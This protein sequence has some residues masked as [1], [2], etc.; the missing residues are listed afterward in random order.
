[1]FIRCLDPI[2][3]ILQD[4]MSILM[5]ASK[6]PEKALRHI[7]ELVVGEAFHTEQQHHNGSILMRLL[8]KAYNESQ[9]GLRTFLAKRYK[10]TLVDCVRF[11][12]LTLPDVQRAEVFWRIHF[13]LGSLAFAMAG[14]REIGS[15][16]NMLYQ[17][18]NNSKALSNRLTKFLVAGLQAEA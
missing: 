15:I 16:A 2:S 11:F 8:T 12:R 1:M 4:N 13:M 14:E 18:K 3:N 5:E 9:A 10:K 17:D 7:V 6:E